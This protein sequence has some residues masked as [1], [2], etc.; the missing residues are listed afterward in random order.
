MPDLILI[1]GFVRVWD[2]KCREEEDGEEAGSGY[3]LCRF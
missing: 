2:K 3:V 1:Y